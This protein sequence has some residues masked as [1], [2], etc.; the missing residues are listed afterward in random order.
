MWSRWEKPLEELGY[1]CGFLTGECLCNRLGSF[2]GWSL[3][4]LLRC[5]DPVCTLRCLCKPLASCQVA[6]VDGFGPSMG[7]LLIIELRWEGNSC[8]TATQVDD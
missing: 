5:Y 7:Q 1:G 2:L 6:C 3:N 8:R 4:T